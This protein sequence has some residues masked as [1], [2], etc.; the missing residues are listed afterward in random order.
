MQFV[1]GYKI[2]LTAQW[3][4]LKFWWRWG[5]PLNAEVKISADDPYL[6]DAPLVGCCDKKPA[7]PGEMLFLAGLFLC[8][9][10]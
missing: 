8:R 6:E 2:A 10:V 7:P 5:S 3:G 9:G 4:M 1:K